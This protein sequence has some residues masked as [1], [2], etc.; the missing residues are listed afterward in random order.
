MYY[1]LDYPLILSF[2]LRNQKTLH[3]KIFRIMQLRFQEK[4]IYG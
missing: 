3:D 1:R 2:I 4:I